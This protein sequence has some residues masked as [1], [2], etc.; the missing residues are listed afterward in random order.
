[1]KILVFD[2]E[3]SGLPKKNASIQNTE[4]WPYI[5]QFSYILYDTDKNIILELVNEFIYIKDYVNISEKS[6]EIHKITR[7]LCKE[8]G[9]D[10]FEVLNK[11][12][13]ALL[14]CDVLVAHNLDFDKNMIL[15]ELIRN[16]IQSKF[17]SKINE[18]C[19]MK[20]NI[21]LCKIERISKFGEKYYKYPTLSELYEYLFNKLPKG[22]HNSIV[23][24]LLCL[25]SYEYLNTGYDLLNNEC[26]SDLFWKYKINTI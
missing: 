9:V 1:M 10:I 18:H 2:T 8:K 19:T 17:T 14:K 4:D 7:E 20:N 23:D 12:N 5:L 15:V 21:N 22:L 3:T 6:I 25:R 11:F 26:I 24:V 16:D 13:S